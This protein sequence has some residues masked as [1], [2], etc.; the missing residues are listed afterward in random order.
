MAERMT[1]MFPGYGDAFYSG[2]VSALEKRGYDK[3]AG[4][5]SLIGV[6]AGAKTLSD[7]SNMDVARS[8]R[9]T[10]QRPK[11]HPA[12]PRVELDDDLLS[13]LT[14]EQKKRLKELLDSFRK[15]D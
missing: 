1:S 7:M 9:A 8:S 5:A 12:A 13:G 15:Q 11:T 14:V 2:I 3:S 6:M 4:V 10:V